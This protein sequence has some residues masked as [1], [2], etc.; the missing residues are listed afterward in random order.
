MYPYAL[1]SLF[2]FPPPYPEKSEEAMWW[3]RGTMKREKQK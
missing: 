3:D 1:F 2:L